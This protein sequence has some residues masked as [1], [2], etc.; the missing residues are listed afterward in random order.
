MSG[1]E[2]SKYRDIVFLHELG[3][4]PEKIAK[5]KK[6][7]VDYVNGVIGSR[8]VS[9]KGKKINV[10]QEVANQNPWKDEL[11]PD[12]ILGIMADYLE[13]EDWNDG[14]RTV[15]SRPIKGVDRSERVGEDRGLSDLVGA[16][17][18]AAVLPKG[19]RDDAIKQELERIE[20]GREKWKD[21]MKHVDALLKEDVSD[22]RSGNDKDELGF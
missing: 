6:L 3:I 14:A 4:P 1:D 15:P 5:A 20:M 10:I 12:E 19:E 17:E 22:S 7:S 16:T 21:I 2:N 18:R 13:A 11:P 8:E 9:T